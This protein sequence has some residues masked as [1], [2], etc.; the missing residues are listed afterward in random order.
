MTASLWVRLMSDPTLL[1][2]T[3]PDLDL[4]DAGLDREAR[5]AAVR[6]WNA[7]A[8]AHQARVPF[9]WLVDRHRRRLALQ[10]AQARSGP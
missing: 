3:T 4:G 10:R 5:Q 1:P 9:D 8:P 7:M 2:A 6:Q